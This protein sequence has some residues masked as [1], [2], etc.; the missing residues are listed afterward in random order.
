VWDDVFASE[1]ND[2]LD[3]ISL[4]NGIEMALNSPQI[5]KNIMI[6]LLNL[7]GLYNTLLNSISL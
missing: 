4:I 3:D 6:A 1:V 5:P 2:V 7:A